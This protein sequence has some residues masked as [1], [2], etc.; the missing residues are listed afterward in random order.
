MEEVRVFDTKLEEADLENHE[1][2]ERKDAWIELNNLVEMKDQVRF[3]QAKSQWVK[4]GDTNSRFFHRSVERKG[5]AKGLKGA[6][7]KGK[8]FAESF[9]KK[10]SRSKKLRM[11]CG[12]AVWRRARILTVLIF[13]FFRAFWDLLKADLVG[14][15]RIP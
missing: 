15:L 5:R 1:L 4:D 10:N 7:V 9:W 14:L 3:Q 2:Q 12:I 13:L 8:W 11:R 6:R